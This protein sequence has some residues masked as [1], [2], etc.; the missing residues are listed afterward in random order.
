MRIA[1]WNLERPK[2]SGPLADVKNKAIQAQ[3]DRLGADIW[4]LTETNGVIQ[5]SGYESVPSERM[6]GRGPGENSTTIWSRYPI[7]G[8]VT[9]L[10]GQPTR[11]MAGQPR[12]LG[13]YVNG[14]DNSVAVCADIETPHGDLRVYGTIITWHADKGPT[15]TA[16]NWDEQYVSI[17]AHA[18]DW[19][20]LGQDRVICVAGDFN[21]TLKTPP[22]RGS[23]GTVKGRQLLQEALHEAGLVCVTADSPGGIDHICLSQAWATKVI[24]TGSWLAYLPDGREVSDHPGVWVDLEL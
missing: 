7:K 16:K 22:D 2:A 24:A 14:P 11:V 15:G 20:R 19:Q 9:T 21:M 23:Y 4:I 6:P 8:Q 18:Q 10:E 3:L 5:P 1:T 17:E 12:P 13:Y